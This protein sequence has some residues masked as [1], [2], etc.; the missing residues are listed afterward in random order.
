MTVT[1]GTLR[2]GIAANLATITGLRTSAT[3]PDA[4]TPPQAVVIPS[5]IQYDRAFHRGLDQYQF[6]ITVLVG[7]ASD[8]NAQSTLDAYC[9]PT[10]ALSI[11]T[12]VESD[13][14][15]GGIAQTLHV[16]EMTSY[17]STSIGDTIY[18][19]ADFSVT[20]YA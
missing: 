11:K 6:I 15:L 20:V 19:S 13:R 2:S 16:T 3:V 4:P 8:R 5:I 14:T 7:R 10:G 17:A 18:L 1:I 9:N 12:A